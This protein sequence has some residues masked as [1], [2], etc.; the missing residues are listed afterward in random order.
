K[1]YPIS[2][3]INSLE[4]PPGRRMTG[5][6]SVQSTTVDS[7]PIPV[8]PS[9]RSPAIFPFKSSH[10]WSAV[11]GL[12]LPDRFALGAASGIPQAFN[13]FDA[14]GWLGIRT[15]IVDNPEVT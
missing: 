10:T 13:N 4:I 15:P 5:V 12:G 14:V 11:V 3:S 9:S 7:T 2:A 6:S 1:A 8:G